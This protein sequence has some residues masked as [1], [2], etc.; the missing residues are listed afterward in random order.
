[1]SVTDPQLRSLYARLEEVLGPDHAETL[2]THLPPRH[3]LA[4][5]GD[6]QEQIGLVRSDLQEQIGLVRS[7]LQEQIGLVRS[8]VAL[9]TVRFDGLDERFDRLED[10]FEGLYSLM[11]AQFRNYSVVAAS[12]MTGMTA[13]FGVML[14][15]FG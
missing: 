5:K 7:D 1:M 2:M 12:F 4:T 8:E 15:S 9:L 11:H 10:R 6:L 3:E 14:A 13:V